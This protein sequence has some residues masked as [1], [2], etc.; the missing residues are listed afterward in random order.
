MII[1]DGPSSVNLYGIMSQDSFLLPK[2]ERRRRRFEYFLI[3]T[4]GVALTFGYYFERNLYR[5]SAEV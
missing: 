2:A 5:F 3:L 4:A 1:T